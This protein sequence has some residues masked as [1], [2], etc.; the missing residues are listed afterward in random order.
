MI[1]IGDMLNVPKHLAQIKSIK[2]VNKNTG[3]DFS[4][5][6]RVSKDQDDIPDEEVMLEPTELSRK[7][8]LKSARAFNE[9]L[10]LKGIQYKINKEDKEWLPNKEFSEHCI[11]HSSN[12]GSKSKMELRIQ[13]I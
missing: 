8:G 7:L 10:E 5:L 6:L 3:L 1:S 2:H 11:R 12:S 13:L 4:N 9:Q